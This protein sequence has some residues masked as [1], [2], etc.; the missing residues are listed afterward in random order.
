V[1]EAEQSVTTLKDAHSSS[2]SSSSICEKAGGRRRPAAH[3]ARH[4]PLESMSLRPLLPPHSHHM[5]AFGA[6]RCMRSW[7]PAHML[8]QIHT[9][10]GTAPCPGPR[11]RHTQAQA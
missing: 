5:P 9:L 2:S 11:R 8:S 1:A 6:S 7:L 3:T 4:V 10:P